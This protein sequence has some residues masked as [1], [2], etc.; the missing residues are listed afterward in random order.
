MSPPAGTGAANVTATSLGCPTAKLPGGSLVS[1]S[2]TSG[3]PVDAGAV[4]SPATG[5][6]SRL[7]TVAFGCRTS[8]SAA[9][10][11][12]VGLRSAIRTRPS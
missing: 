4:L 2:I 12:P 9:S 8:G 1:A 10:G 6:P 11:A 3:V 5:V 7:D